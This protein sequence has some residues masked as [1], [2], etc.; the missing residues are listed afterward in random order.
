MGHYLVI[1]L[2]DRDGMGAISSLHNGVTAKRTRSGISA[3]LK[4]QN[5]TH[6]VDAFDMFDDFVA[7]NLTRHDNR[8]QA[9]RAECLRSKKIYLAT[10]GT[11]TDVDHA[12]AN[13]A[14]GQPLATHQ[15]LAQFMLMAMPDR[16][17]PYN[18]ALVMCYGARTLS[19]LSTQV[20]HQGHIDIADLRTSFAYKFYRGLVFGRK[21]RMTARTGAV[22][23]DNNTGVSQVEPEL[24]IDARIAKEQ[25]LRQP[26]VQP[27]MNAWRQQRNQAAQGGNAT[28]D[29][30]QQLNQQFQNNP[31]RAAQNAQQQAV[32]DYQDIMRTKQ[33]Y[34]D[35]MDA[36]TDRTKYG[37]LVYT[38]QAGQLTIVNKYANNG[39]ALQL[40]QGLMV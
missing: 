23:F 12:F 16:P 33:Q 4:G 10:H 31:F 8:L 34:V 5:Q 36:N 38:Y 27:A 25:F 19:Y 3:L 18:L 28:Y 14:G 29:A 37:K 39:G 1:N 22:A 11:P 24:A 7:G 40:Y 30:F 15:Q 13:A 35:I 9:L 20:D 21:V 26:H 2:A 32:K 6:R 17:N